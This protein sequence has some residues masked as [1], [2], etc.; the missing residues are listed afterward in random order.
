MNIQYKKQSGIYMI[1]CLANGKFYI[2]SAACIYSR[3]HNH[4]SQLK[5]NN[6]DNIHL[7]RVYIKY[8]KLSLLFGVIEFL[9][10]GELITREQYWIDNMQPTLNIARYA[11]NTL[12]VKHSEETKKYLSKIRKGKIPTAML[13]KQH[14][15]ETKR[16]ISNKAKER[17]IKSG[18]LHPNFKAGS[19]AA[20]TGRKH[21]KELR[22]LIANIQRKIEPQTGWTILR[23]RAQ[24]VSQNIVAK[25]FGISQRLVV[26]VEKRIGIYGTEEYLNYYRQQSIAEPLFDQPKTEQGKLL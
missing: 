12:G 2:G 3:W 6:H 5:S 15:P 24:G 13:G 25:K 26:R 23:I 18:G 10:K 8:G 1:K 14:T 11:Q 7:Q 16:K 21:S 4:L 9:E 19:I 17:I 22:E 20:N